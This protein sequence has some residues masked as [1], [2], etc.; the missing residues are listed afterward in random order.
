[1]GFFTRKI[2]KRFGLDESNWIWQLLNL[3]TRS[4]AGQN[5]TVDT[6][7]NVTTVLACVRVISEAIASTPF[8]VF[9]RTKDRETDRDIKV[10]DTKHPLAS[11]LKISPNEKSKEFTAYEMKQF[12]GYSLTLWGNFY[13]FIIQ[14]GT[15]RIMGLQ[16]LL[17]G[18][19]DVQ[20]KNG[21]IIFTYSPPGAVKAMEF[22]RKEI[23]HIK[24]LSSDGI[25]GLSPISL[26]RGAIG[27][28]MSA[29]E[30]GA[31]FF[32]N[33]ARPTVALKTPAK[34][35]EDAEAGLKKSW[36]DS[37]NRTGQ[38]KG[39]AILQGSWDIQVIGM[40][41]EDAQFLET[42]QFQVGDI[43]RAFNVPGVM[44]GLADKTSTFASAEQ[45]FLSFAIH[46]MVPWFSMIENS[47]NLHLFSEVDRKRFFTEFLVA[48]LTRGDI[49]TRF[50]AY[51]VGIESR[52]LNPNEARAME[53]LN[54]YVGGD[55]FENPNITPGSPD[56]EDDPDDEDINDEE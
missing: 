44:V 6:A 47:A 52:I 53:N 24:G 45:F 7:L 28:A 43:A 55:V 21:E 29:E 41:N 30:Y 50:D 14:N 23:W 11:I 37:Y 36:D 54:P 40:P 1:M 48:S 22:T 39:T 3:G 33:D 49:K 20:R 46:T 18:F 8:L 4:K 42:R 9:K 25:V 56:S 10:R 15:G 13:A 27:L 32:E 31:K 2:E 5:V 35:T 38:G 51:R 19:M 16:P 26:M 17:P 34:L 12:M